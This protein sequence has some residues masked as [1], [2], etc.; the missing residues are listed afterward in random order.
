MRVY[1]A[2]QRWQEAADLLERW[3]GHV[4]RPIESVYTI[5]FLAQ[6]LVALYHTGKSDQARETA[7]RLFALTKPEGCLRVYLDEGEPM[8]QALQALLTPPA[9]YEWP[10]PSTRAYISTLLTA[11]AGQEQSTK[12][13]MMTASDW[14]EEAAR[15]GG[16]GTLGQYL[17]EPLTEREREVLRLLAVGQS[18]LEIARTLYVEVNTVKTHL[19]RLYGKLGVHSRVQAVRRAQELS[20]L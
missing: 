9:R 2:Q 15:P 8:R 11:I 3:R 5:I 12:S 1:F 19:K 4:D 17:M 20:I 14:G 6:S 10:D 18:N 7:A 16:A 13:S